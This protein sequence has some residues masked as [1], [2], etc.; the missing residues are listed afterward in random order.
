MVRYGR[1][2]NAWII[3]GYAE[4]YKREKLAR[5]LGAELVFL[6]V[7]KAECITRLMQSDRSKRK[8]EWIEY[9]NKWFDM[10]TG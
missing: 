4:K 9:I 7:S 3:G 5:D 6:D 8:D 1:W 2:D 10:Y